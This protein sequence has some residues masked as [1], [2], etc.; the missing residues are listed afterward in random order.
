MAQ[1]QHT[2]LRGNS[3]L[4]RLG[5]VVHGWGN[6]F[7]WEPS[8]LDKPYSPPLRRVGKGFQWPGKFTKQEE[9]DRWNP[10]PELVHVA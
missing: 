6:P 7:V 9:M 10:G 2:R 3:P 5:V 4:P 8:P 1:M